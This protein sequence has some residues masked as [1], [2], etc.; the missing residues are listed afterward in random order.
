IAGAALAQTAAAYG[1]TARRDVGTGF[2]PTRPGPAYGRLGTAGALAWRL[3]RGGVLGWGTGFLVAGV[4]FGAMTEGAADLL[5]DNDGSR[6]IL[7]RMGGQGTL[8]DAF[9]A[10]MTGVL[11]LVAA[12]Y[13]VSSVLRLHGEESSGRAEPVLA[14]AAGR[15]RWAA[16]HLVIAFG[17]A[18][19]VL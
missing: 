19:L 13:V 11:G 7:G 4:V 5:T 6:E 1:L 2:L 17:G 18:V 10:A 9:V 15:L 3:Q 8:T 16:G 14:G 12:L